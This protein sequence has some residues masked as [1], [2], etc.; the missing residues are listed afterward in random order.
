MYDDIKVNKKKCGVASYPVSKNKMC[1]TLDEGETLDFCTFTGTTLDVLLGLIYLLKTHKNAC[2]T[3]TDDFYHNENLQNFYKTIGINGTVFAYEQN[4]APYYQI[5]DLII[6]RSG[7][8]TLF[9]TLFFKKTCI[10]I[11]LETTT[12]DH[13]LDNAYALQEEYPHLFYV[14][15]QKDLQQDSIKLFKTVSHFLA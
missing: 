10:T 5:A 6:C 9:E 3:I 4:L 15:R 8:G 2:S 11:P 7:A 13:Q 12:T 14:L 1:I